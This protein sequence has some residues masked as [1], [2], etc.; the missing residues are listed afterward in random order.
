MNDEK[1]KVLI[2]GYN[3]YGKK[4]AYK[5]DDRYYEVV[6]IVDTSQYLQQTGVYLG[7]KHYQCIA[8]EEIIN[9]QYDYII[10]A[11]NSLADKMETKLINL[12]GSAIK[13]K[14]II[15]EEYKNNVVWL[16]ERH[17]MLRLC[18]EEI[19]N[20]NINGNM[21]ELGVYKGDFAQ[22]LNRYLPNKK[23]YLFDTFSGFGKDVIEKSTEI[24]IREKKC[25]F[26][27][28][29][30]AEVLN[31]MSNIENVVVKKGFFPGT[32]KDV[33]E[34]FCLVSIDAD[35]YEPI[36]AGLEYFY[37]R[38]EKGGYIFIHD[39]GT[40]QFKGARKAVLEYCAKQD[41]SYVPIL[42]SCLSVIITK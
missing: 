33:D 4:V 9:Y 6:A 26:D 32:A 25:S 13:E 3:G 40:Y 30:V 39:F 28:T 1:I 34:K 31:K 15:F 22:Y 11:I 20:K 19:C 38:L 41:I 8:E 5:L 12:Y 37:P 21:A 2:R 35:L 27:D 7:G 17:A 36:L 24:G 16:E 18:I 14:I 42:D 29:S 10:L 23:L